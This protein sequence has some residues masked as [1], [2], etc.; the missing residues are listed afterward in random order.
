M[1][2]IKTEMSKLQKGCEDCSYFCLGM[3]PIDG[4]ED[5]VCRLSGVML[6]SRDES[7]N[8]DGE[9]RPDN[10]PLMELVEVEN[11]K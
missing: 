10:C 2:V 4:I 3:H 7:R 8:Y 6:V 1:V 5:M 11:D 9:K